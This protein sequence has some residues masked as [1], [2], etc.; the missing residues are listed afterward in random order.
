MDRCKCFLGLCLGAFIAL[1]GIAIDLGIAASGLVI[2]VS[3]NPSL[4]DQLLQFT[5]FI[6]VI[7]S[8]IIFLIS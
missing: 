6:A 8:I 1:A 5:I 2:A 3:R 4:T 7:P